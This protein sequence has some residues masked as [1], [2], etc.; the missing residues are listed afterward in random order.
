MWPWWVKIPTED[1]SDETLTIDD[2]QGDDVSGGDW[3]AG[4]GGW[5]S[6]RNDGKDNQWRL[7]WYDMIVMDMVLK[8]VI[9]MEVDKVA[10]EG[11]HGDWHESG[12]TK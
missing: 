3:G 8:L 11:R 9:A 1:F 2:T 6:G 12:A 4:H 5:Q 10:D 7:F